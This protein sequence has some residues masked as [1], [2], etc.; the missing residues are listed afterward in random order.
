MVLTTHIN[1]SSDTM[2]LLHIIMFLHFR[3]FDVETASGSDEYKCFMNKI[4]IKRSRLDVVLFFVI[5]TGFDFK[6]EQSDM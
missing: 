2:I 3:E 4:C 1:L 5:E 6:A